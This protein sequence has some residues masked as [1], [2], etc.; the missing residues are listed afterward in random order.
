MKAPSS[1]AYIMGFLT[2]SK[3]EFEGIWASSSIA[4]VIE[5]IIQK[6]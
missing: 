4:L 2:E 3:K 1:I 5:L 6:R